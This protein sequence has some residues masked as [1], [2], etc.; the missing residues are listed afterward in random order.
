MTKEQYT[1]F[2][3]NKYAVKVIAGHRAEPKYAVGEIVLL[4]G[5]IAFTKRLR[6][7][8]GLVVI[9]NK[10]PIINAKKGNKRYKLLPIG[11]NSIIYRDEGEIKSRT[12]KK[13]KK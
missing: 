12:R 5:D 13:K 7:E 1:K 10:E 4:R 6:C 8:K 11:N 3:K 9:S 2:T